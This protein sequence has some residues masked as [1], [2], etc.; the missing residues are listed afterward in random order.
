MRHRDYHKHG[1]TLY[2]YEGKGTER[3]YTP[4]LLWLDRL[5]YIL[6]S[7]PSDRARVNGNYPWGWSYFVTGSVHCPFEGQGAGYVE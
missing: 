4:S 5:E 6:D 2:V 3:V 7:I 1:A